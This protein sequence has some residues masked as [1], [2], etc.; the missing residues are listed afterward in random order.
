MVKMQKMV[1]NSTSSYKNIEEVYEEGQLENQEIH[2]D[3]FAFDVGFGYNKFKSSNVEGTIASLCTPIDSVSELQIAKRDIINSLVIENDG[4]MFL[5]GDLAAKTNRQ[6]ERSTFRDR[7]IDENFEILY[8]A[9]IVSAY[10]QYGQIN[11]TLVTGLPNDDLA[12][13]KSI[14]SKINAIKKIKY[15]YDGK[16]YTINITYEK[17]IICTQPE[18]FHTELT[19][20]DN[21]KAINLKN[22]DNEPLSRVGILDFGHGTLNMSLFEGKDLIRVGNKSCSI[23]GMN[24]IYLSVS[25]ALKKQFN[26]YVPAHLD[27]ETAIVRNRIRVKGQTYSV[28]KLV[29]PIIKKYV[30][31]TFRSIYENWKAEID[32]LSAIFVTGGGSNVVG[33]YLADEFSSKAAYSNVYSVD[34]AQLLNVRGYFKI[35][36]LAG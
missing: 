13:K 20:D 11:L 28:E 32:Q 15:Y 12:Q 34:E 6:V 26:N 3:I 24:K 10:H 25:A 21:L 19:I 27:T 16:M 4:Q 8:K 36:R 1:N 23:E 2:K 30:Q 29:Q 22:D 17:L 31:E 7:A 9:A 35:G 5:V 14:E 18:G 33:S